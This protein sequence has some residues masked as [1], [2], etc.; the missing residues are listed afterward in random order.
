MNTNTSTA[1][2]VLRL[3]LGLAFLAHGLTKLLVFTPVGTV[4]FFAS[5]GIPPAFAYLT[6]LGETAGGLALIVGFQTRWVAVLQLP[7]LLGAFTVHSGNGWSFTNP[8]GGWEYVGMWIAAQI[9]LIILG[10]GPFSLWR[11]FPVPFVGRREGGVE[12]AE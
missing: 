4:A 6:M 3:G 5:L 2:L 8:G 11:S 10:D 1:A 9:A 7:I 12:A